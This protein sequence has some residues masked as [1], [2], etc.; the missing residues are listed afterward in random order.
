MTILPPPGWYPDPHGGPTPRWWDGRAWGPNATAAPVAAAPSPA[1][2]SVTFRPTKRTFVIVGALGLVA[3]LSASTGGAGAFLTVLG[4]G[5]VVAAIVAL[6][7]G[8]VQSLALRSRSASAI[9]LVSGL[10]VL[11]IGGG[12]SAATA[13]RAAQQQASSFVDSA[14]TEPPAEPPSPGPA[15]SAVAVADVRVSTVEVEEEVPFTSVTVDDPNL[16][17]GT[18]AVSTVGAPGVRVVSYRVTTTDGV[19]TARVRVGDRIAVPPVDE[20]VSRGTRAAAP[21]PPPAAPPASSGCDPNYTGC[22]PIASDVDCA[23]GSGNGP[24]YLSGTVQ[25]I[26]SDIYDLDRDHDGTACE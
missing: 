1:T 3:L 9:A 13:P 5:A 10:V 12:V 8:G 14:T 17:A 11:M 18:T 22:V 21:A 6:V 16:A 23:G 15:S 25:V 26:G 20:V 19:E 24:A 2:S 7:R 4:L